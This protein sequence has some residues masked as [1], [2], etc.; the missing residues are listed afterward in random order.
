[1]SLQDYPHAERWAFGDTPEI[2]NELLAL[3][4]AGIKTATCS[5]LG[6]D[7]IPQ[8]GDI[9]VMVDGGSH[10]ACAIELT[11]VELMRFDQV[12]EAHAYA[13]GEGDRSLAYWRQEHERFFSA[14]DL[15]SPEMML[16]V[17]NFKVI[18]RF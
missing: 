12:T 5:E 16:I 9:I 8:A 10:P 3:A 2:A 13:E 17:M 6:E 7:G 18:A 15:F 11:T 14:Y 1:M 4:L